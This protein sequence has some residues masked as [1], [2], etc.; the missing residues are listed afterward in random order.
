M[1]VTNGKEI[2]VDINTLPLE[3]REHLMFYGFCNVVIDDTGKRTIIDPLS[4]VWE[5]RSREGGL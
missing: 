5:E 1:K 4:I 3:E 2:N